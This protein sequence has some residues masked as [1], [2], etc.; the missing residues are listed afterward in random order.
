[1]SYQHIAIAVALQRYQDIPPIALRQREFAAVLA[2]GFGARISVLSVN[3][4]IETLPR[5]E[6]T[7]D[8]L[9]R[10]VAPLLELSLDASTYFREGQPS[11]EI[12]K[13]VED[14]HVDILIIGS[15][16]KRGPL[17]VGLGST[18]SAINRDLPATVLM[19]RPTAA[20]QE[21]ARELMIPRY[22]FIFPY[23]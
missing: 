18:A 22:P 3:A 6:T 7:V 4:P 13:F 2:K 21:R 8:K 16:S 15:H 17:D 19:I 1:M 9:D 5:V 20:E 23:Q 12:E 14:Q 10:F 11:R